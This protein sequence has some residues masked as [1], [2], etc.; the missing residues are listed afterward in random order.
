M[1]YG[2]AGRNPAAVP[3]LGSSSYRLSSLC[4][5]LNFASSPHAMIR[6][7]SLGPLTAS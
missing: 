2:R 5:F 6:L 4:V 1:D 7:R 3:S